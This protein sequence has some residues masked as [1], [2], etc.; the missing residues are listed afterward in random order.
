MLHE[1][2]QRRGPADSSGRGVTDRWAERARQRRARR[3]AREESERRL[4][5]LREAWRRRRMEEEREE[6]HLG[7]DRKGRSG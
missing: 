4:E 2:R 7:R 5:E 3:K 6:R 1:S